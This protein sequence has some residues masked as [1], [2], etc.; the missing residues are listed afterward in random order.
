MREIFD[1]HAIERMHLEVI[2]CFID[3]LLY[4]KIKPRKI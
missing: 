2:L 3:Q 1:N 4:D